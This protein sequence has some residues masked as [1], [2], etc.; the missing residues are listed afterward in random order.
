VRAYVAARHNERVRY[1]A[2]GEDARR[3]LAD[4]ISKLRAESLFEIRAPFR[5][6]SE[7]TPA[8]A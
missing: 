3:L 2:A 4:E 5:G 8:T 7:S 6:E 1:Y